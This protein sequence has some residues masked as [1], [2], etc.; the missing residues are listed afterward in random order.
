MIGAFLAI[1]DSNGDDFLV[2]K[3]VIRSISYLHDQ[4]IVAIKLD[5]GSV[6]SVNK[7]PDEWQGWATNAL[8]GL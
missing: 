6:L 3:S 4:K 5:D 8:G 7:S 1:S 2:R